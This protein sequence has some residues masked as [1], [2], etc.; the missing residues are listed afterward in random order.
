MRPTK[1]RHPHGSR[2]AIAAAALALMVCPAASLAAPGGDQGRPPD[3]AP[4]DATVQL[5]QR[6]AAG[7][8]IPTHFVGFSVEWS[9]IE[10][11]MGPNARRGFANLLG[12]LDTGVLRIGGSSQDLVPFN[13]TAPNTLE[14]I[15]PE[16]LASIRATLDMT[17]AGDQHGDRRNSRGD[18]PRWG[19]ILGTAM[20]PVSARRPFISVDHARAFTE[21][22]VQPAFAGEEARRY[23]AGIQLGNEP[24]LSY[25]P[26]DLVGY[27]ADFTKFAN[28]GVSNDFML[29]GPNTSEPIAPWASIE[30]RTVGTR[31]FWDWPTILD[32]VTPAVTRNTGA[33]GA[34]AADHFYPMTRTCPTDPYRCPSIERLLSDERMS[35]FDYE[36]Y[37]HAAEA[38]RHGLGYRVE[39]L[40]TASGRG[41]NGVSNVAASAVWA[42][43]TLFNAACPQPPNAPGANA[44]CS[45]GAVGLNIHN[46]EVRAFFFPEEGNA[47]YNAVNYD[48]SPAAGSPTAAPLYYGM[49]MFSELAQGTR[50]LHPVSVTATRPE[51]VQVKAWQVSSDGSE[52]RLFLINKGPAPVTLNVEARGSR[53]ELDWMT[54]Y[55]PTGAGRTLDAPEVRIDGQVIGAD[56]R[57]P[58]LNPSVVRVQR[59][60]VPVRLGAG[61]AVAVTM[62]GHDE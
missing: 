51:G 24:D 30:G 10:R 43:D 28:A 47:F 55:D 20:A 6:R 14:V 17:N 35:N 31:F 54:P 52:R 19:T 49:L 13:A 23:V 50:G 59:G 60:R 62:K 11:Y 37:T 58:G 7:G 61:E 38:A 21:Q 56:A 5:D 45:T 18:A 48:P 22:G 42:L 32:T 39:E 4:A 40:N 27:L 8:N 26:F 16:D 34:F 3:A 46:A 53:A 41:A 25:V 44:E 2:S 12:N 1:P 33:F 57:W 9:L 36:V 29:I 15:T